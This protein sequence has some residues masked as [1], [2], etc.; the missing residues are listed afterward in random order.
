MH[1][2]LRSERANARIPGNYAQVP[3]SCHI[4]RRLSLLENSRQ[5]WKDSKK[6]GP[7]TLKGIPPPGIE[8]G[9]GR[10]DAFVMRAADA[11]HYTMA[12]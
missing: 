5:M 8:P 2:I 6:Q 3:R 9:S 10:F 7:K 1:D 12:D 4:V 11:S